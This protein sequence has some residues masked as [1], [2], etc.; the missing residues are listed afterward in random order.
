MLRRT[1]R[2]PARADDDW[3]PSWFGSIRR[4]ERPAHAVLDEVPQ[5]IRVTRTGDNWWLTTTHGATFETHDHIEI[6]LDR[7]RLLELQ[8]EVNA[9]VAADNSKE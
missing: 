5:S 7:E 6:R 2:R 8:R 9:A 4:P 3:P 1:I